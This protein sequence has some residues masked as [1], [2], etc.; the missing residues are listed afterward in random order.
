MARFRPAQFIQIAE[1]TGLIRSIGAWV[2]NRACTD[3]MKLPDDVKVAVNLS[4]A[5]FDSGDIVD[6]VAAALDAS[7]LPANRLELEITETTLAEEQRNNPGV[8]VPAART[9]PAHCA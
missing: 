8:A 1:E 3:A 4:G 7:G 9:G 2:L 6:I 5:Q